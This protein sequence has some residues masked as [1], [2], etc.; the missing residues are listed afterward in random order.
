ML[1]TKKLGKYKTQYNSVYSV[2]NIFLRSNKMAKNGKVGDGHRSCQCYCG[3][4]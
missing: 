1:F 4:M 3:V 2:F